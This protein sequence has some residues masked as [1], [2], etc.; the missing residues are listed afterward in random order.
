MWDEHLEPL[1]SA[2]H[3]VVAVDLPGFGEAV[4]K[5]EPVAHWEDV[6][7][8]MDG[9]GI[10]E[11][12][13]V[14]NSF[15]GSVA[16]RVAALHPERVSSLVL[17]SSAAVPEAD[18]S[19]QLLAVW[20]AEEESWAAGDLEK[21]VG[22]VVSGWVGP[23]V[24]AEAR[25]RIATMQLE[26]YRRHAYKEEQEQASDPLEDDPALAAAIGCPVLL[27]AGENDMVDF[28][29]AVG[30]LA[31]SMPRATTVLIPDC[32]HLAPLEA[33]EAFRRLVIEHLD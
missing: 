16:L 25:E 12:S 27:A 26:N 24:P 6:V 13:L 30:E 9:L 20:D 14:G 7:E 2:G 22:A 19:P 18:P 4:S 33:P 17:F 21:A 8:T 3:R 32:G 23:G 10:A 1:A 15:G 28:R 11:A 5:R 29:N 31:A